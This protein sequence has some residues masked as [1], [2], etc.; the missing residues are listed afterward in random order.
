MKF[1]FWEFRKF[2]HIADAL[3]ILTDTPF[4]MADYGLPTQRP[5]TRATPGMLRRMD[6]PA[7]S[8]GP[9]I[10]AACRFVELT[11][12]LAGIG[13]LRDAVGMIEGTAGTI[14]TPGGNYGGPGDLTPRHDLSL[15]I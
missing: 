8:M 4:V 14:I 10:E 7:G 2:P 11:G 9:K 5:I 3:L 13:T 1:P 6:F 15:D 12:D